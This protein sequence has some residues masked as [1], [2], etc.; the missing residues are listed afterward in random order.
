[1]TGVWGAPTLNSDSHMNRPPKGGWGGADRAKRAAEYE[2]SYGHGL[3]RKHSSNWPDYVAVT[4]PSA[5]HS[6]KRYLA[7]RPAG[8]GY[9]D[10]LDFGQLQAVTDS[11]P[12]DVELVV[13]IGAGRALDASKY[14]ALRMEL[15]L[16]IVPTAVS[17]GAII[18]GFLA[19]W[20]GRR[21]LGSIADCPG[22]TSRT[23]S[24]TT[25]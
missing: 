25:T 17:T 2:I 15:P 18:H 13:G 16:L 1:M 6:A 3:V 9:V 22:S 14:V 7:R 24:S 5:Y 20:E 10:L 12:A 8:V 4:T 11:L 19:R 23:S 21:L